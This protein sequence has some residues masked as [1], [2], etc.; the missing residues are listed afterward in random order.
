MRAYGGDPTAW[1]PIA[2]GDQTGYVD[3]DGVPA[4][5]GTIVPGGLLFDA[6]VV[7]D[8]RGYNFALDGNVDHDYFVA[9]LTT[10]IFDAAS[11]VDP[12]AAP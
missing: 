9:M 1:Q 3:V 4:Q 12:T 5:G 2:S 11:A 6:V 7:V 8:G 10:V